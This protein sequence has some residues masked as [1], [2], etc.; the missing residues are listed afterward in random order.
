MENNTDI[1]IKE[2]KPNPV[3]AFFDSIFLFKKKGTN[4]KTEL[5]AGILA[6]LALT[7]TSVLLATLL[8]GKVGLTTEDSF[9]YTLYF[10]IALFSGIS[11]ILIGLITNVPLAHSV[12]MGVVSLFISIMG[13]HTGLTYWNVLAIS[14]VANVVY[15]LVMAIPFTRNFVLNA[16]PSS[17]KKAMPAMVGLMLIVYVLVQL[18]I[19]NVNEFNIASILNSKMSAGDSIPRDSLTYVTLNLDFSDATY[20]YSYMSVIIGFVTLIIYV[21][22]ANIKIKGWSFKHP[23]IDAFGL[24]LL[25]YLISWAIRGNFRDYYFFS[26]LTPSYGGSYY[27]TQSATMSWRTINASYLGSIFSSGF[28]FSKYIEAL[29]EGSNGGLAVFSIFFTTFMSFLLIGISETGSVMQAHAAIADQKDENGEYIVSRET[30]LFGPVGD[31]ANVYSFGALLSVVGAFF[32]VPPMVAREENLV[33][34][35]EGGRTGLTSIIAGII[36]IASA[37]TFA[38]SGLFINGMVVYGVVFIAGIFAFAKIKDVN[39]DD[40]GEFLPAILAIIIAGFT[41]NFVTAIAVGVISDIVLKVIRFRF[42]EIKVGHIVL[43][44]ILLLTLIF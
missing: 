37:F 35:K 29:P 4:T 24:G 19:L 1:T 43:A 31:Y 20:F 11:S 30:D 33:A 9:G 22:L 42:K 13:A 38:L 12:S 2:K 25:I 5:F 3:Y 16:V 28:D 26:F 8:S 6:G 21:V 23:L 44:A 32:G 39:W 18:G 15:L 7:C 14:F 36:M 40:M 17:I 10:L 41:M 27:Y 34:S